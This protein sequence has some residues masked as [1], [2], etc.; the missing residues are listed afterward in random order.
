MSRETCDTLCAALPGAQWADPA[1]GKL[2]SWKVG[3]KMFACFGTT[4][5][6]VSVK[7]PSVEDARLLIEMGRATRAKYFHASW[8]RLDLET[9]PEDEL[10]DRIT[11]SY[12]LVVAS[13]PKKSRPTPL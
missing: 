3:D 2:A 4:E 10:R 13:L 5:P 7:T 11:T 8:V 6:G 1:D 9:L 12:R